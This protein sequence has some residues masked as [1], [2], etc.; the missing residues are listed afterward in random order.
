[1]TSSS[2]AALMGGGSN[3]PYGS[4]TMDSWIVDGTFGGQIIWN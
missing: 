2:I 4:S 1:M 3:G